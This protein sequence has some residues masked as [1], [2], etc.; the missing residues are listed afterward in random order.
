[1]T[2]DEEDVFWTRPPTPIPRG[3]LFAP[4][5]PIRFDGRTYEWTLDEKR[6]GA[7]HRRIA[8]LMSD[9]AWRTLEEIGSAT[10]DPPASVSAR[11]RDFRKERFGGYEVERRRRSVALHEYRVVREGR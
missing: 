10:N 5:D 4:A 7:Q 11:L 9:G 3:D 2:R 8:A 1:M 6:L